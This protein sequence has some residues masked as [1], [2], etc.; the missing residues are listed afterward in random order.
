MK[1]KIII[2]IAFC[3]GIFLAGISGTFICAETKKDVSDPVLNEIIQSFGPRMP[4]FIDK[5]G[6]EVFVTDEP[7]TR[8]SLMLA[9]YEYDKSLKIQKKDFASRQEFDE[10]KSRLNLIE[11]TVNG[12]TASKFR[13]QD[14]A[15]KTP[16]D[17]TEIINDMMTNMPSLLD[18]SLNNSKVFMSLKDEVMNSKSQSGEQ[19]KTNL[20]QTN[21]E[22]HE[23]KQ[24]I[25]DI[26]RGSPMESGDNSEKASL[27]IKNDLTQ[28]RS[29]LSKLEKRVSE[30]EK[31]KESSTVSTSL[32]G[33]EDVK[34][35]TSM[36]AK[37][38]MGLS[39][40]AALFIA[41]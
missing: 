31:T 3:A 35:Y 10:L 33:T 34:S 29:Q 25:D 22:L 20:D 19:L 28:T 36:L 41:R 18:N 15:K 37:I 30:I 6:K 4:R 5:H 24:K 17:T 12:E 32:P 16:S 1:K 2:F 13:K 27:N 26:Q 23:L 39:M 21:S 14:E 9:L 8:G 40:V 38:S 7:V 11:N